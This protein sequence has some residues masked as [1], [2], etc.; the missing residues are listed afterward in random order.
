[1]SNPSPSTD[2]ILFEGGAVTAADLDHIRTFLLEYLAEHGMPLVNP[3]L[4]ATSHP[5]RANL[6]INP[7]TATADSLL[8]A[9]AHSIHTL[10][11]LM[12]KEQAEGATDVAVTFTPPN[13]ITFTVNAQTP[14]GGRP[15]A[16]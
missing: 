8:D 12:V 14:Q 5:F 15:P 13:V 1:M 16:E 6:E 10:Y 2:P 11:K 3:N 9:I 4:R 7:G